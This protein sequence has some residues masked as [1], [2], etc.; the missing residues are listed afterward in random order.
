MPELDR[1]DRKILAQLQLNARI[2]NTELADKVGLSPTPCLRRVKRLEDSGIIDRHVTL[3]NAQALGLGLTAYVGISMD[4]HTPDRFAAF[5][6]TIE[7][8]PEILECAIVTGQ[9]ADFLLKVIVRDMA[10]YEQFLLG[11]LAKIAGVSG[12]HTSFVLRQV[13][14]KTQLPVD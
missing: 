4:R 6:K 7:T 9:Q 11:R 13:I 8:L 12:V 3:L 5:E 10:H 14:A 2:T 1:I